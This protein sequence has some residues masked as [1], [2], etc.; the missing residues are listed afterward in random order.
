MSTLFSL[1]DIQH[2]FSP[3]WDGGWVLA[4]LFVMI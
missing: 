4:F 3:V 1:K 2:R